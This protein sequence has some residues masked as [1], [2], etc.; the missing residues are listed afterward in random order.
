MSPTISFPCNVK[1]LCEGDVLEYN[2]DTV[3]NSAWFKGRQIRVEHISE[4]TIDY[5]PLN[6]NT[7]YPVKAFFFLSRNDINKYLRE[8]YLILPV[9]HPDSDVAEVGMK[10]KRVTTGDEYTIDH[11]GTDFMRL[12]SVD[13]HITYIPAHAYCNYVMR[14]SVAKDFM[15]PLPRPNNDCPSLL[16]TRNRLKA[17]LELL[18]EKI[19]AQEQSLQDLHTS[20]NALLNDIQV[21]KSAMNIMYK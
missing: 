3:A 1:Q 7:E 14:H 13:Q 20:R 11:I 17:Q 12:E 10:V 18:N 4:K 16:D 15:Q 6:D 9:I 2:K 19:T 8:F 21:I 5:I